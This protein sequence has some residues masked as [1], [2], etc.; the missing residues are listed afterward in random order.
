MDSFG[1][2]DAG[3]RSGHSW[4]FGSQRRHSR[5]RAGFWAAV[6]VGIAV[7]AAREGGLLQSQNA[8][9]IAVATFASLAAAVITHLLR[10]E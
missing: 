3:A 1:S 4:V 2:A 7:P 5:D 6:E 10:R 8:H 9:Q